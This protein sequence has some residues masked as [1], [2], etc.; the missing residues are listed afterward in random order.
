[1]GCHSSESPL[2]PSHL[3]LRACPW[4]EGARDTHGTDRACRAGPWHAWPARCHAASLDCWVAV[5]GQSG[6][7]SPR[8]SPWAGLLIPLGVEAAGSWVLGQ[9]AAEI[10]EAL[11]P[12]CAEGPSGHGLHSSALGSAAPPGLVVVAESRGPWMQTYLC[13]PPQT[14][15]PYYGHS[16]PKPSTNAP[17]LPPSWPF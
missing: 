8:C 7:W 1:M 3:F 2:C 4:Q 10:L 12:L 15:C 5:R 9:A 17:S 13:G 14:H 11:G 6:Q 16:L